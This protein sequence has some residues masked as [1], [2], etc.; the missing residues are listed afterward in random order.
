MAPDEAA[1][2]RV[3]VVRSPGPDTVQRVELQLPPG[4]SV[5]DALRATGWWDDEAIPGL[6][7]QVGV[8]GRLQ[9][10]DR[11]L[12]DR[13]RVEFYRSLTVD[14]KEARRLRYRRDRSNRSR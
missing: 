6:D 13:D 12:R 9:P 1:D 5:R 10:L 3:E 8:W 4:A 11:A 14:P 2:L 7:G